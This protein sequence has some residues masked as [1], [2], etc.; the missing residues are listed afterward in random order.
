MASPVWNSNNDNDKENI[1]MF[2]F[3]DKHG[4]NMHRKWY[5]Y[6]LPFSSHPGLLHQKYLNLI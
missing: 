6:S 3:A 2:S 5:M 1:S 4:I